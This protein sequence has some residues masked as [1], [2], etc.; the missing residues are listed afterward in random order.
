[1]TALGDIYGAV[2]IRENK[3]S[4]PH[5]KDSWHDFIKKFGSSGFC[6]LLS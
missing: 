4:L 6:V 2:A 5:S 3:E 1:M